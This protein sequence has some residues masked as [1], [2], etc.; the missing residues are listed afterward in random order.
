[1]DPEP[2]PPPSAPS[3]NIDFTGFVEGIVNGIREVLVGWAN[4]LPQTIQPAIST[5]LTNLWGDF[6][7]SGANIMGTPM[8]LTYLYPPGVHLGAQMFPVTQA[9]ASLAVALLGLRILWRTMQGKPGVLEDTFSSVVLGIFLSAVSFS[10]LLVGFDLARQAS[11]ALG[12]FSYAPAMFT[13]EAMRNF[14]FWVI[15]LL[16]MLVYGWRLFLRGAYRIVLLMFLSPFAPIAGALVCIPQTRWIAVLYWT[17]MGGWLAGGALALGALSMGVQIA[18]IGNNEPIVSL[19]FSVAL[20]QLAH[21]LMAWLPKSFSNGFS[22][23]PSFSDARGAVTMAAVAASTAGVPAAA[24][25]VGSAGS[26]LAMALPSGDPSG[27]GY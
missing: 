2:T 15:T 14:A 24:G 25:V 5:A 8:E 4:D 26:S 27:Y 23:S 1:M 19:L 22:G 13:Q 18:T 10:V 21:D 3:I 9:I 17:T 6:W 12:L 11:D 7:H 20:M 16:I